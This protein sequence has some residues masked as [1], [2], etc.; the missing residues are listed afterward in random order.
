MPMA[1]TDTE[2]VGL[3]GTLRLTWVT[4]LLAHVLEHSEADETSGTWTGLACPDHELPI[5]SDVDNATL[6]RLAGQGEIADLVWEAPPE[7]AADHGQLCVA[8]LQ[9]HESGRL[10]E[11]EDLWKQMAALWS[12]AWSA[13]YQVLGLMQKSG[14]TRFSP[15]KPQRWV[16]ASF[17]HHT[18]PH[19]LPHPHIHNIVI[20]AL[21]APASGM[22]SRA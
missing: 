8:A 20:P 21:T 16:I 5:G 15:V 12:H 18:S 9:A 1:S 17:E 22:W 4:D 6:L 13:N 14:L 2:G 11:A 10:K 19:G 3:G 7:F